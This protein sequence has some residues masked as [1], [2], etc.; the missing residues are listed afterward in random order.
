MKGLIAELDLLLKLL[1][2]FGIKEDGPLHPFSVFNTIREPLV[3]RDSKVR[4]QANKIIIEIHQKTGVVSEDL[5]SEFPKNIKE[6][7][8]GLIKDIK[9][10]SSSPMRI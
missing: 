9:V 10:E 5:L 8:L 7:L 6:H 1:Q 4:N 3:N 2:S